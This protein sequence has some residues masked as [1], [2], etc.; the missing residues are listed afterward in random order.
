MCQTMVPRGIRLTK[1]KSVLKYGISHR[2][3]RTFSDSNTQFI[4]NNL[5]WLPIV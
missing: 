1:K 4:S 2:V 3:Q 5:N